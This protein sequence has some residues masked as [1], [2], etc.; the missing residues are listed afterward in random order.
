MAYT[1]IGDDDAPTYFKINPA[2]GE[3]TVQRDLRQSSAESMKVKKK[4]RAENKGRKQ[5]QKTKAE[6]KGNLK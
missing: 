5:R 6:N 3:I 4:T 2:G 1:I